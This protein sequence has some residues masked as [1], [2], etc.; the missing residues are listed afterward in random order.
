M[1]GFST[2]V[3]RQVI[4]R[5]RTFD[6]TCRLGELDSVSD[7]PKSRFGVHDSFESRKKDW[8]SNRTDSY[9]TDLVGSGISLGRAREAQDAARFLLSRKNRVSAWGV[10]LAQRALVKRSSLHTGVTP[11]PTNETTLHTE[12][13]RLRGLV[14]SIPNDAIAWA[15]LSRC[16]ACLGLGQQAA[17]SMLI[18]LKLG[19]NSRFILRSATRLWIFLDDPER[20]YELVFRA[21]RT[22]FD[23]WLLAAEIAAGSVARK[24]P[25]RIKQARRM[26]TDTQ[27]EPG[28][29]SE[30]A[31]ALATLELSTGSVKKS[32]IMFRK[33]LEDPTE[34]SVAQAAWAA[35]HHRAISFDEQYLQFPNTFEAA[36]WS[37]YF[38]GKWRTSI[39]QCGRW[40]ADQL[41]STR[42][43]VHGSFVAAVAVEDYATSEWFATNGLIANPHS[44]KLLN[45]LAFARIGSGDFVGAAEALSRVDRARIAS[46]DRVVLQATEGLLAFRKGNVLLGRK[47]YLGAREKAR[48]IQ[49]DD[50]RKL[51]ALATTF[52]AIEEGSIDMGASSVIVDD[53]LGAIKSVADPIG[54]LLEDRV[55]SIKSNKQGAKRR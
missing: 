13:R 11:A 29:L 52:H 40:Q 19:P 6:T 4:P 31:S 55:A 34:N 22:R 27:I 45:N 41:F 3:D 18:A 12:V 49:D 20:A 2:D 25:A 5:W 16:Y 53:A 51:Y 46:R 37:A 32:R 50:G 15:E 28:H 9:A 23:P 8:E 48:E 54:R 36:S 43:A 10:E 7:V 14:R 44:F 38:N 24:R 33:S 35:R 1:P 30:L 42:P 39:E 21:D 17:R 47:L 26:I